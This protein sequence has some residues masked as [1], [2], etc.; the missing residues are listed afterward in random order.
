MSDV[1][2]ELEREL[3]LIDNK[4]ASAKKESM[5]TCQIQNGIQV[6]PIQTTEETEVNDDTIISL[7]SSDLKQDEQMI[8]VDGEQFTESELIDLFLAEDAIPKDIEVYP[9]LVSMIYHALNMMVCTPF[10]AVPLIF[11]FDRC[12]CVRNSN[13]LFIGCGLTCRG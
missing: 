9:F 1:T 2:D 10:L 11:L 12:R 7:K 6:R 13:H 5:E 4:K 8:E 3:N